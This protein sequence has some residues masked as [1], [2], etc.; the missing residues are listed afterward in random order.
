[1]YQCNEVHFTTFS[2]CFFPD[3]RYQK[4]V[5]NIIDDVLEWS[6]KLAIS[7]MIEKHSGAN[8]TEANN[9]TSTAGSNHAPSSPKGKTTDANPDT[10]ADGDTQAD[11]D[12]IQDS[13]YADD[14]RTRSTEA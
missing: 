13:E 4:K 8:M 14:T 2:L 9:Y 1:M 10:D 3:Y 11:S 6:P 7:G 5:S 12:E